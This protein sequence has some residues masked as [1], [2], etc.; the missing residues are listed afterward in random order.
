MIRT[1]HLRPGVQ[2]SPGAGSLPGRWATPGNYGGS[3]PVRRITCER[4]SF[5][6]S[7]SAPPTMN[8]FET[9]EREVADPAGD[10]EPTADARPTATWQRAG[11]LFSRFRAGDT[12]ALDELVRLLTPV[13]WHVVRAYRLDRES[14]EDVVQTAWLTLVRRQESIADP[15]AVSAW[16][17]TTARREAWRVSRMSSRVTAAPDELLAAQIPHATSA[18]AEVVLSDADRRLWAAV[19]GLSERCRRLLRVVAFDERPDYAG[20]AR[21]LVMPIGS[22]GPTRG[23]CLG[24]L[25][26]ALGGQP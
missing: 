20:L 19:D 25:R 10:A 11:G 7:V 14:A 15:Q 21:D 26:Q 23:R 13:L 12:A 16:V 1:D 24:K 5:L 22:I 18:E 4:P 8:E 2:G 3:R 6:Q 17:M 9:T